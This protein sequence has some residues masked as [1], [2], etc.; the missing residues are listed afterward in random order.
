MWNTPC[1][2]PMK[3]E[4]HGLYPL[5]ASL[6]YWESWYLGCEL[7]STFR[8]PIKSMSTFPQKAFHGTRSVDEG[9]HQGMCGRALLKWYVTSRWAKGPWVGHP[10]GHLQAALGGSGSLCSSSPRFGL[11][12]N[13]VALPC[14]TRTGL[15]QPQFS[16]VGTC[17][18]AST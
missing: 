3:G 10:Q 12:L 18:L 5:T 15:W 7:S 8:R 6:L 16:S 4:D 1:N 13:L 9:R 2:V 14:L 17:S 11:W